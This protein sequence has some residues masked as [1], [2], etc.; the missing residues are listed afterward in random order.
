MCKKHDSNRL[1]SLSYRVLMGFVGRDE[2][3]RVR[4][5]TFKKQGLPYR[6]LGNGIELEHVV[7]EVWL[8]EGCYW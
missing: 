2:G 4:C 5:A 3:E 7:E 1:W 6:M 8:R